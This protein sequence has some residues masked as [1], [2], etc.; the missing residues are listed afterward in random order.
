MTK[1]SYDD[2]V[3]WSTVVLIDGLWMEVRRGSLTGAALRSAS[4]GGKLRKWASRTA[5]LSAV[6]TTEIHDW[7]ILGTYAR[8]WTDIKS[9]EE[10]LTDL[11]YLQLM[12]NASLSVGARMYWAE[13]I[14][15]IGGAGYQWATIPAWEKKPFIVSRPEIAVEIVKICDRIHYILKRQGRSQGWYSHLAARHNLSLVGFYSDRRVVAWTS[16]WGS[17]KGEGPVSLADLPELDMFRTMDALA[18]VER[19]LVAAEE[20]V[21][22]LRGERAR[23]LTA[24]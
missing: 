7:A 16:T 17:G 4:E 15:E 24:V 22:F 1:L 8:R 12:Y 21:A 18:A 3:T 10:L 6:C 2:G 5:W 9:L 19:A 23:L 11:R 13:C 20:T 14:A